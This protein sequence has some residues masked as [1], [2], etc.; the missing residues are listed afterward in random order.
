MMTAR[1]GFQ[2]GLV[3]LVIG[4]GAPIQGCRANGEPPL[5]A[6]THTSPVSEY[7]TSRPVAGS[8]RATGDVKATPDSAGLPP[9]LAHVA[10]S[11]GD[12]SNCERAIVIQHAKNTAEG[13]AA[14][15]HWLAKNFPHSKIAVKAQRRDNDKFF[16]VVELRSENGDAAT[17][18]F[19]VTGFFGEW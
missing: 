14:E 19:D 3:A 17:V 8:S 9:E 5:A 18:C 7:G 16:E 1:S 13:L 12:G 2:A 6:T 4:L 10:F 11:G 15:R